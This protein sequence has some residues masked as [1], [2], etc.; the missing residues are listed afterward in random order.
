MST[1]LA[2]FDATVQETN[3]WLKRLM[4]QMHTEHRQAAYLAL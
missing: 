2:V 1:G 3:L 4:E